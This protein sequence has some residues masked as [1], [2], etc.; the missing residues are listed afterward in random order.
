MLILLLRGMIEYFSYF[1]LI[2][3]ILTSRFWLNGLFFLRQRVGE[4]LLC[5]ILSSFL[6]LKP[7]SFRN[8]CKVSLEHG[9]G[10][11]RGKGLS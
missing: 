1:V 10:N 5:L 7:H 11:T 9:Q 2:F 3:L 6:A 8:V 4:T